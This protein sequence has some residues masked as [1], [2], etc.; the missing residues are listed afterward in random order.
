MIASTLAGT[1]SSLLLV[2]YQRAFVDFFEDELVLNG[3][4]WRKVLD[5]YLFN[6]KEPLANG[7]I[8]GRTF[9]LS[10]KVSWPC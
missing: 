5:K 9:K 10:L 2:R 8:A 7:L 4:D 1:L 3:Y 6:G